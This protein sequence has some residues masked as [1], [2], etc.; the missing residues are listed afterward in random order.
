MGG[1]RI[2]VGGAG[3]RV[4]RGQDT[5]GQRVLGGRRGPWEKG[6]DFY[7]GAAGMGTSALL[8]AQGEHLQEGEF[9]PEGHLLT[10]G[11]RRDPG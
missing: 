6:Q 5:G 1:D 11:P 7:T 2:Q 10:E 3:M 8:P 9:C 4:G